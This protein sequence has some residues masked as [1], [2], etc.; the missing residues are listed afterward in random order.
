MIFKVSLT[1]LNEFLQ[2]II[3]SYQVYLVT[4]NWPDRLLI[5]PYVTQCI[6]FLIKEI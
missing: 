2:F 4:K 1:S 5:R 3:I 6:V